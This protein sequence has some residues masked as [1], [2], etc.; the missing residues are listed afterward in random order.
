MGGPEPRKSRV[1]H[2]L[3]CDYISDLPDDLKHKIFSKLPI[4]DVVRTSILSSKWKDSWTSIPSLEFEEKS[5]SLAF[6]ESSTESRLVKLVDNVLM[7]HYGPILK[8]KLVSKNPCNEAIGRWM[9]ILSKNGI[10]CLELRYGGDEGCKI[11]SRLF[12]CDALKHVHLSGCIINVP[13]TFQGFKLLH[14]LSLD[15]FHL[16]GFSI[17]NLASCCPL[18]EDLTLS[19]FVLQGCL[20]ILAPNLISL[21]IRGEFHDLCLE[22]PKLSSG[23]IYLNSRNRDYIKYSAAKA[24]KRSNITRALGYLHNIQKLNVDGN[25]IEYLAMGP[26]PENLPTIF[27]H[28]TEIFVFVCGSHQEEIAAALCLFKSA[29]NLKIL[30]IEFREYEVE[31][32]L[33]VQTFWKLEA[34]EGC[35][36]KCLKTVDI[37]HVHYSV[38]IAESMLEFAKLVLSTSPVLE[39]LNIFDFVD[40]SFFAELEDF[41]KLSK[42]SEVVSVMND[43]RWLKL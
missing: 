15:R 28:L 31:D 27:N 34:T 7:V 32:Q 20:H 37:L 3:H 5:T 11:P 26:I 14:A 21:N 2:N 19:R 39:K 42:K 9:H 29:P 33:Q 36:F 38:L 16:T 40:A 24:G 4:K 10:G 30:H 8:F 18:L 17:G 13:Q 22:T 43:I 35:L 6:D 41:P 1:S 12:S 25:F 23:S